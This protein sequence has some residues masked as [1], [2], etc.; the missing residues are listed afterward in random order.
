MSESPS[1]SEGGRQEGVRCAECGVQC[2]SI[3]RALQ[4]LLNKSSTHANR[5]GHNFCIL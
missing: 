3:D 2:I 4:L 1:K 5:A